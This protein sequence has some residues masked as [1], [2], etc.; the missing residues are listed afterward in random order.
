MLLF[1]TWAVMGVL[2]NM[3]G[4]GMVLSFPTVLLPALSLPDS[5]IKADIYVASWLASVIGIAGI[6]G[7]LMSSF[8]MDIYGRKLA[9]GVVL[10]PGILGWLL[11]YFAKNI[12]VLI[13]GRSLCGFAASATVC[14]G[15]VVIG[16]YTSPGN[17]GMFLNLKTT[18]V[19]VGNMVVHIFGHFYSYK[20]V[21][22]IALIPLFL[23]LIIILTW[24]E[25]PAWLASRKRFDE[26]EKAFYWLRGKSV[27]S[28][29]ELEE[30]IRAQKER[31]EY[32]SAKSMPAKFLDFFRKFTKRD[33][34]KPVMII[35]F[36]AVLLE[37]C[38][39]HIFPAYAL[40]I[41]GEVTESK[42]QSFYFTLGIDSIISISAMFSSALVKIMKRRRLLFGS[43]F[44][45]VI[46]LFSVCLYLYLSANG[47]IAKDKSWIAIALFSLYFILSNL[48]CTPIPL[49]LLGEIFP[50]AHRG[51]GSA[52]AGVF[53]SL[54]VMAGMQ[55]TPFLL[56]SLKVYGTFAVF[57]LVMG[58]AL[59]ALY[60]ILPETKDRT[61]QE[62]EDYFN[63]GRYRD[64]VIENDDEVKMKMIPQ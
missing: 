58:V 53:L 7:F 1:Q 50:L 28:T 43:G 25:S 42:S 46:V 60:F 29:R 37:S 3:L 39:R 2:L 17:R 47:Y 30:M 57:G 15:A 19:C 45:A 16:E 20:I 23:S 48:G 22:L 6:P 21:A 31:N 11:I 5:E 10:I 18:A 54:A 9:H 64:D 61:L 32:P 59:I 34:I 62:I 24:P 14:L 27:K 55:V 51:A 52:V 63:F 35:F 33:F 38:G 49:A 40:Q 8:L 12:T 4:Q 36:S 56:V 13:I 26:S 41:I 44:A